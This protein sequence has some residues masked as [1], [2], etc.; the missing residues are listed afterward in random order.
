M[1]P[2][3]SPY[4]LAALSVVAAV[5]FAL[6]VR[7][8]LPFDG[9]AA[10]AAAGLAA[11]LT[12]TLG[13]FLPP[14]WLW[15]DAERLIHAFRAR[16]QISDAR[17]ATALDAITTAHR[18]AAALRA[19]SSDFTE[20]LRD[21]ALRGA[22]ALDAAAREIFYD[23]DALSVHRANLIRAE[24]I[25]DSVT[26][27]AALRKRNQGVVDDQIAQSREKVAAALTS[28]EG[29]FDAAEERAANI[30][31]TQVDVAS[32]TA[33]TLLAPR[34]KTAHKTPQPQEDHP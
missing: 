17:A 16:H 34:Q 24:L 1:T 20:S 7:L 22:D 10:V 3:R 25:E 8:P 26:A 14:H 29:A 33:E 32:S 31:L 11:L 9:F 23:P 19:A 13:L 2:A 12:V 5:A 15:T 6:S 18:R 21:Q 28:L 30:L 27:H 4:I